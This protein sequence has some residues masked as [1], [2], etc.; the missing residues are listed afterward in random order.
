MATFVLIPGAGSDSWYWHLVVPRLEAAGHGVV[1]VD[2]PCDDETATFADYA[3]AVVAAV[4]Q[5][6]SRYP[7]A[8]A[9]TSDAI[10]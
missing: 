6:V 1:A 8:A 2:V 4:E 10:L 7:E 9:Y 5:L 3:D